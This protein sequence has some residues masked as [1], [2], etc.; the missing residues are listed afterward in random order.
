[1]EAAN[2]HGLIVAS[3]Y[4]KTTFMETLCGEL[5]PSA[6]TMAIDFNEWGRLRQNQGVRYVIRIICSSPPDA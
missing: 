6:G 4:G 2:R 5:E 1:M 3:G